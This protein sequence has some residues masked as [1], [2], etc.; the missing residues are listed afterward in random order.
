MRGGGYTLSNASAWGIDPEQLID[1]PEPPTR[2]VNMNQLGRALTTLDAPPVSGALRVQ[3]QSRCDRAEPESRSRAASHARIS[4]TVVLEQTMTDTARLRRRAAAGDDVPRALRHRQ[5]HGA[6]HLHL[7][8]PVIAP[9]GEARP[10]HDVF[11]AL[12]V[13]LGLAE[14]DDELGE[15]GALMDTTARL[16]EDLAAAILGGAPAPAPGDGRPSAVRAVSCRARR[17]A[18]SISS[19]S[20]SRPPAVF[21]SYAPDPATSAYPLALISPASAHTISSTLG[22]FRPGIA[23]VKMHPDDAHARSIGEADT[24]RVFNDLGEVQC[25]ATVTTRDPARA[26]CRCRKASGR[27]APSTA[28]TATALVPD[29]LDGHRRWRVLQRRTSGHR[30]LGQ[31]RLK[32]FSDA[33]LPLQPPIRAIEGMRGG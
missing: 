22:E 17:T 23:R 16:P 4:F 1:T 8:Q 2:V 15:A 33:N 11:R 3:Q 10:N 12:G 26:R 29:T 19:L 6:Y 13:R 32:P 21:M 25:E 30:P 14:T 20:R 27:K 5:G 28:S 18:A 31:T 24:V 9:L 7:V